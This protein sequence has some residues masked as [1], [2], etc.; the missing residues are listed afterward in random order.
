MVEVSCADL[1]T[2][3]LRDERRLAKITGRTGA[4]QPGPLA[5]DLTTPTRPGARHPATS[6]R[7]GRPPSGAPRDRQTDLG[8]A[9]RR[10][11]AAGSAAGPQTPAR[12]AAGRARYPCIGPAITPA[13][14]RPQTKNG[15]VHAPTILREVFV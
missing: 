14:G 6:V 7:Q 15:V 8:R 9:A 11:G 1:A 5:P 10:A 4:G 13:D 2:A 3:T 12:R